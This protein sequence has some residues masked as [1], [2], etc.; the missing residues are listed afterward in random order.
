VAV[1]RATA[2]S[3]GDGGNLANGEELSIVAAD[4]NLTGTA[5]VAGT[6][7]SGA[8]AESTEHFRSRVVVRYRKRFT[9]GSPADYE[10]WGLE[11]PHFVW[12]SPY[13]S[14]TVPGALVVYGKV[15]N[16]TDGI[17]SAAQ[18]Q[19]LQAYIERDPDTGKRN[20]KPATD[21]VS[22]LPI[23]RYLLN[24]EIQIEDGTPALKTNIAAAIGE[25]LESLEPYNEGVSM[26]RLDTVTNAG[27]S[28]VAQLLAQE[29]G[30]TIHQVTVSAALSGLPVT[31]YVLYGGEHAKMNSCTFVDV[32]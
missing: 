2:L 3:A 17:P 21:E 18:L 15:D 10:L 4:V 14:S 13:A 8:D 30:A 32:L 28:A 9:G 22:Y 24:I 23:S 25:Y 6:L 11:A 5:T 29:A 16:Q 27:I 31:S 20:R 1:C 26:S 19:E 12:V 7:T